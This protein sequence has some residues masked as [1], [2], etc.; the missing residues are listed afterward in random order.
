MY[1]ICTLYAYLGAFFVTNEHVAGCCVCVCELPLL[2]K[3]KPVEFCHTFHAD[4]NAAVALYIWDKREKSTL[5]V[6]CCFFLPQSGAV[7]P[8][9][10]PPR[11]D[12]VET[13][14][15]LCVF[16][17]S[18]PLTLRPQMWHSCA[19]SEGLPSSFQ[20]HMFMQHPTNND[21]WIIQKNLKM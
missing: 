21:L 1:D 10:Y 20:K 8:C 13:S 7:E 9:T 12:P 15:Y 5:S 19:A 11:L 2:P 18:Q 6:F 4:V 14:S 16:L 3:C 17:N